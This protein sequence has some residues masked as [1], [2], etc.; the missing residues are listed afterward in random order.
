VRRQ[1]LTESLTL[2][3]VGG[4]LGIAIAPLLTRALIAVYPDIMPRAEEIG[5]DVRV[6]FVAAMTT[7]LAGAL[8]ALPTIRRA[9]RLDLLNDLR[10]GGRAG[11]GR[12]TRR[13]GR[14]LIVTQVAASLALLFGAGLLLQTFL[15]L[16]RARPGFDAA[17]A[18]T[19]HVFAPPARYKASAAYYDEATDALRAI[20]GIREVATATTLP[21]AGGQFVDTYIQKELGDQGTKNPQSIVSFVSPGYERAMGIS[22]LRGRS[23]ATTDDSTSES[24]VVINEALAK[25]YYAATDPIGKIL[26]WNFKQ[27]RI[28]GVVA[29]TALGNLWEEPPAVLYA[30]TRQVPRRGRYFVLR[31]SLPASQ[32][33]TAARA[34]LHRVDPTIAVT[35]AMTMDHRV[36]T[37][38]SE[39]RFRA[40]LMASLGGLAL[41]LAIVGIYSVVAQTV[42]RQTREIG[43]RMALGEESWG[44]RRRVVGDA[45]RV[46]SIGIVVGAGLALATGRWLSAFLINVSPH[47]FGLLFGAISSLA[48]VVIAA[49]YGPARRAAKIDPVSALRAE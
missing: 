5:V 48:A 39:Q 25:R 6:L 29:S 36:E 24:V 17:N 47:D 7:M 32:V 22:V 27:W 45:M 30:S 20:P 23:F 38:L 13:V 18:V 40:A 2:A 42:T 8:S 33:L 3:V 31:S 49:A 16:T 26:D 1:I 37:S 9:A 43:I 11:E 14:V 4:A 15:R 10:D 41:V 46:A 35:D 12:G 44:V 28:V 34:A 21:F 19:F